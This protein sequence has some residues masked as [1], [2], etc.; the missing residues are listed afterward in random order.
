VV[1]IAVMANV[2]P[3]SELPAISLVFSLSLVGTVIPMGV[4]SAAA[5]GTAAHGTSGRLVSLPAVGATVLLALASIPVALVLDVGVLAVVLPSLSLAPAMYVAAVR[6]DLIGGGRFAIAAVNYLVESSVRLIAGIGLGL[7]FGAE[8][9]GAS[10]LLCSLAAW[11]A[12]PRRHPGDG[13]LKLPATLTATAILVGAVNWDTIV[14]PRLLGDDASTF[15]AAALP[16]KGVYMALSAAAWLVVPGAL[17][18]HTI[19]SVGKPVGLMVGAG[20]AVTAGLVPLA[21]VIGRILDQPDPDRLLLVVLGVAMTFGGGAW[22]LLQIRLVRGAP[23]PWQAPAAG[24]AVT[25][26][27][28]AVR[29]PNGLATAMLVGAAVGLVTGLVQLSAELRAHPVSGAEAAV[30][31]PTAVLGVVEPVTEP[32]VA[33]TAGPVGPVDTS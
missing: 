7:A 10:L 18:H 33:P 24:L 19:R 22:A 8:G 16:A 13:R 17:R 26:A 15:V 29:S 11:A 9:V 12:G 25:A 3:T 21:P 1:V 28:S 23:R 20:L 32:F 4:Q 5:A 27:L 31:E 2:R 6:G 14:A 30:L